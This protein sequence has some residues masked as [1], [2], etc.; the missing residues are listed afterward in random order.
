VLKKKYTI[1]HQ[2]FQT[3]KWIFLLVGKEE[4]RC[5]CTGHLGTYGEHRYSSTPS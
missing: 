3:P 4:E 2:K 1:L 5:P